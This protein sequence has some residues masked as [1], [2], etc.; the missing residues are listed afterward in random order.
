MGCKIL[1]E[2]LQV[3]G[4]RNAKVLW[5][6][7]DVDVPSKFQDCGLSR[8]YSHTCCK[9]T[10]GGKGWK[11]S[12]FSFPKDAS[13]VPRLLQSQQKEFLFFFAKVGGGVFL[14]CCWGIWTDESSLRQ[15]S[16]LGRNSLL[17]QDHQQLPPTSTAEKSTKKY[18]TNH[19]TR[20]STNIFAT[21][22]ASTNLTE[23]FV[24]PVN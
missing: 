19:D 23:T 17:R 22:V 4:Y 16:P 24:T 8:S 2:T 12:H 18:P 15:K 14:E 13:K 6:H 3:V 10:P 9:E 5:I 21:T 7:G 1:W 11:R 20:S